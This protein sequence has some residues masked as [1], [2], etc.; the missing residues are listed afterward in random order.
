MEKDALSLIDCIEV[1]KK[2]RVLIT[3][4]TILITLAGA[5]WA[6]FGRPVTFTSAGTL[7]IG[8]VAD[9]QIEPGESVVLAWKSPSRLQS[10]LSAAGVKDPSK[11]PAG[12]LM[13]SVNLK[14]EPLGRGAGRTELVRISVTWPDPHRAASLVEALG[15]MIIADH[16]E[17]FSGLYSVEDEFRRELEGDLVRLSGMIDR[18]EKALGRLEEDGDTASVEFMLL[19]SGLESR[20]RLLSRNRREV[21]NL[22]KALSEP[23]TFP[24]DFLITP[25]APARPDPRR[26]L[27]I[28]AA[29]FGLGLTFSLTATFAREYL[30]S[31][32][33]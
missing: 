14:T 1:V 8:L 21:H 29:A 33:R 30:D 24:T 22:G 15:S 2:R 4:L 7:R 3:V 9:Q 5:G 25:R 23:L 27:L 19:E 12:E 11:I 28:T 20:L 10:A 18:M 16:R 13:R 17:K 32:R 6:F 31:V 26:R